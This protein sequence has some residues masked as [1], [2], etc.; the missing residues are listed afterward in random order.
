MNV[1]LN[2]LVYVVSIKLLN[3]SGE[4]W[5]SNT[6]FRICLCKITMDVRVI[7]LYVSERNN[8]CK[9]LIGYNTKIHQLVRSFLLYV[10][11]TCF[12]V[13]WV[14]LMK[15]LYGAACYVF[16]I[17]TETHSLSWNYFRFS[18][19]FRSCENIF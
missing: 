10:S 4:I 14:Y 15:P 19:K 5:S 11:K 9:I 6:L 1:F 2:F 3:K 7:E 18:L 8:N 13:W 12:T 17:C 16:G